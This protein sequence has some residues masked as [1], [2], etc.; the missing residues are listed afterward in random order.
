MQH[1]ARFFARL[2]RDG[3]VQYGES[4]VHHPDLE[5]Q[6]EPLHQITI[7]GPAAVQLPEGNV[8]LSMHEAFLSGLRDEGYE[9]ADRIVPL[10]ES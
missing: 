3:L 6:L 7:T 8:T 5:G 4:V 9:V 1:T 10:P 2:M